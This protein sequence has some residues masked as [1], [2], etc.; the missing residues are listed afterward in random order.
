MEKPLIYI[1]CVRH[2]SGSKNNIC[3]SLSAKR[4]TLSSMDGTI[5]GVLYFVFA[6]YTWRILGDV[7][8]RNHVLF[9]MYRQYSSCVA[10]VGAFGDDI[11]E[12]HTLVHRLFV[13]SSSEKSIVFPS[14]RGGVPVFIRPC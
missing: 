13:L 2:P 3:L 9:R 14:N 7:C 10:R 8:A 11:H 12:S 5:T 4:I 1:S 6:H